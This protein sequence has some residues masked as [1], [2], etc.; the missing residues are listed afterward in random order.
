MD[1]KQRVL[2]TD[3]TD[4]SALVNQFRSGTTALNSTILY[5]GAEL[6]FNHKYF[7]ISTANATSKTLSSVSIWTGSAWTDVV[8]L[9]DGTASGGISLAQSG[10]ISWSRDIMRAGWGCHQD[11]NTIP[12][13][14]GTRIFN[15]YWSRFTWSNAS[16]SGVC[17]YIGERFSND[18]DLFDFYPDLRSTTL[19]AAFETGKTDWKDQSLAAA[20]AII[21][22]MRRNRIIVRREQIM[23]GSLYNEASIHKTAQL[24]FNGLGNGYFERAKIAQQEFLRAVDIK[25]HEVDTNAT[26]DASGYE[27]N[28]TTSWVSR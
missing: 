2:K 11:S 1:R 16:G 25:F 17:R 24:I 14:A 8:D 18:D 13:L 4:V 27:K 26:G 6:P 22:H 5:I 12:A 9:N 21:Q 10:T 20:D 19:M 7:D 23:D 3:L 28:L 15:L